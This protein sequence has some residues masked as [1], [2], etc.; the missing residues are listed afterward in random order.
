[1]LVRVVSG[2][3]SEFSVQL[4]VRLLRA[5]VC[6]VVREVFFWNDD[7]RYGE[8]RRESESRPCMQ[9]LGLS[10]RLESTLRT[11]KPFRCAQQNHAFLCSM[12]MLEEAVQITFIPMLSSISY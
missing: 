3:R 9:S 1:M 12:L 8:R 5:R 2:H 4:V 7:L 10:W 11:L 6:T